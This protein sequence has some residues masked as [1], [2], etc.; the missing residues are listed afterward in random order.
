MLAHLDKTLASIRALNGYVL[1]RKVRRFQH[2]ILSG[3]GFELASPFSGR[4]LACAEARLIAFINDPYHFEL[5]LYA[6]RFEDERDLWVMSFQIGL[7]F[8]LCALFIDGVYWVYTHDAPPPPAVFKVLERLSRE[9][10]GLAHAPEETPLSQPLAMTG[11]P[12]FAHHM[13]NEL[14]A[15]FALQ[16]EQP[17]QTRSFFAPLGALDG[18]A[19]PAPFAAMRR[20]A[21]P[22]FT[23]LGGE[24]LD[25]R[26]T[27]IL[28]RDLPPRRPRTAATVEHPVIWMA[29][30]EDG[31]MCENFM[32]YLAA[33][34]R[35]ARKVC[36]PRYILDSFSDPEDLDQPWYA[37][38]RPQ[39][40]A[41]RAQSEALFQQ[42]SEI[43]GR[44]EALLGTTSGLNVR[45]AIA[46]ARTA[47]YYI[48]PVGSIQHKVAWLQALPGLM[49]GPK[50]TMNISTAQWH[51]DQSA[52]AIAPATLPA[53]LVEDTEASR[54]H[55]N[56]PRNMNYRIT[57]PEAAARFTLSHMLEALSVSP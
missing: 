24:H 16:A 42:M 36:A 54:H 14:P 7:G 22:F 44:P 31:R 23:P 45:E 40:E 46:L 12:N 55:P 18:M 21:S 1:D 15:L 51:A 28:T 8:P 9:L 34:D 48:T 4:S 52:I 19:S 43:I 53:E 25:Q 5:P 17:V 41:R 50:V 11:H 6:Y 32:A 13:W 35:E 30:R 29:Y 20:T 27:D 2:A 37:P 57:D 33:F 3:A 38:V 10:P 49:H 47:D 56:A 26:T 39:F